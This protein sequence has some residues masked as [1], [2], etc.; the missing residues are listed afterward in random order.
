MKSG[1]SGN[2]GR[3]IAAEHIRNSSRP[4]ICCGFRLAIVRVQFRAQQYQ[5]RDSANHLRD[6]AHFVYCQRPVEECL[7]PVRQPFLEYLIA[8]EC[9]FPYPPR[10]VSPMGR[11]VEVDVDGVWPRQL[12][13]AWPRAAAS[14]A[15]NGRAVSRP[16]PGMVIPPCR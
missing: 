4:G 2:I 14:S 16:L 7:L 3:I 6:I 12:M 10:H 11:F 5:H 1:R 8:A 9:V 15:V 13:P